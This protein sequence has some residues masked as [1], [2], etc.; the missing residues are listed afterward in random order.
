M[1]HVPHVLAA[2]HYILVQLYQLC[3][4]SRPLAGQACGQALIVHL[5]VN[6]SA[7]PNNGESAAFSNNGHCRIHYLRL[8]YRIHYQRSKCRIHYQRS[9]CRIP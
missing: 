8:K 6:R 1:P 7:A 2:N 5:S 9:K 4:V 3:E